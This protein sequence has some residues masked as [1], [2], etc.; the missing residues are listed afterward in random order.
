MQRYFV[1]PILKTGMTFDLDDNTAKHWLQVMRGEP[2][3]EAEFVDGQ[4]DLYLG[5]L[6]EDHRVQVEK[7]LETYVELPVQVTI[8]SGLPKQEKAE[9]I[10]QKATEMGADTVCFFGADWSVA[11]WQPNKVGKKLTR[12]QKIAQ[13]AAEQAH[14]TH[15][16][17]VH[18]F[19]T[20]KQALSELSADHL[21]VAYEEAAKQGEQAKLVQLLHQV[22]PGESIAAVFGP[23]GGISPAEVQLLSE[24]HATV[25]GLGPRILRTETAPLY[26]LAAVSTMLELQ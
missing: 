13:G 10:V 4:E 25:A 1:K 16:P 23:E 11:K 9:W 18:F 20:L 22:Q 6:N 2:G 7:A 21:V 14:R 12:L 24:H 26:F 17:S 3:D 5:R 19:T 15:I 8:I